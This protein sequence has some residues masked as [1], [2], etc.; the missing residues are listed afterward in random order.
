MN[1]QQVSY[2][3]NKIKWELERRNALIQEVEEMVNKKE[4]NRK[5]VKV[6]IEKVA[7][8]WIPL[9]INRNRPRMKVIRMSICGILPL[10]R[11]NDK[12]HTRSSN[13]RTYYFPLSLKIKGRT[14]A[15]T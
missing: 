14:R 2:E 6:G 11:K 4:H 3:K 1:L 7:I 8:V 9:R 15:S 5:K 10:K 12:R 13:E